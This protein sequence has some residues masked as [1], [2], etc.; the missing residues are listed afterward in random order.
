MKLYLIR[1]GESKHNHEKKHSGQS[2]VPLT[3]KGIEQ[4]KAVG[5]IIGSIK[6]DKIFCSDLTR[7]VMT[8]ENAL[9]G[10]DYEKLSLIR[11]VNVGTLADRPVQDCIDE[12]GEK[13]T[14]RRA[15]YDFTPWGGE[16]REMTCERV[17]NFLKMIENCGYETVA[18][19]GHGTFFNFLLGIV[20][21]CDTTKS[22]VLENCGVCVFSFSDGT[23]KIHN[24][25]IQSEF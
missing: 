1:H 9:P 11:E 7:A 3:E 10:R 2:M 6:F 16:N 14:A 19:F 12:Y 22:A 4:A 20:L 21:G 25:N 18:A 13:Y 8:C 5:K 15:E 17:S 24:W 23:W